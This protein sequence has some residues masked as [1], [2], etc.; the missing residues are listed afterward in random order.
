M[1]NGCTAPAMMVHLS[2]ISHLHL[3]RARA[4]SSVAMMLRSMLNAHYVLNGSD[5]RPW[6]NYFIFFSLIQLLQHISVRNRS[7]SLSSSSLLLTAAAE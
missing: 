3:F 4:V 5:C 1:R 6:V 2:C 7:N